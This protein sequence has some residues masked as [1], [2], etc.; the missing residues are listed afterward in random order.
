M[1]SFNG[2]G[3]HSKT[4]VNPSQGLL[5][6]PPNDERA[7]EAVLG[8][9]LIDPDLSLMV[10][11][12]ILNSSMFYI[13]KNGWIYECIMRLHER[14]DAVD[15]LTLVGE[16]ERVGRLD[17]IGGESYL[18]QLTNSVPTALNVETYA[19]SVANAYTRRRMIASA[20]AIAKEA[21]DQSKHLDDCMAE[22]G[23]AWLAIQQNQNTGTTVAARTAINSL[24]QHVEDMQ[25][26]PDKSAVIGLT[27]GYTDLDK[28]TGGLQKGDLFIVAGRPGMGKSA[29]MK[30]FA[31]TACKAG[32]RVML[33]SL[34]MD[35]A[36]VMT[37]IIS[38]ETGIPSERIKS[39]DLRDDEWNNFTCISMQ[40]A[41][42][43]LWID[44]GAALT[45]PALRAKVNRVYQQHGLD[46]IVVDYLQLMK[47]N[48]ENR[49]QEIGEITM[50]LKQIARE[51]K[52]PLV[53]GAQL[54]RA[55][56]QRNDKRPQLSDL[57]E[58]GSIENDA[59]IV[60]FIYRDEIYNPNTDAKNVAEIHIGK[61]RNGPTGYVNLFFNKLLTAFKPLTRERVE[62]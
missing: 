33:F 58:S 5:V 25:A 60:S 11:A 8:S 1:S 24:A 47:G 3:K 38:S 18:A 15:A 16:L 28:I 13:I 37:R 27:T 57:R 46:L 41:D 29:L 42:W 7:E 55:L 45:I 56:E 54:S 23:R 48:A 52:V 32:K 61:N 51:F 49:V 44:E 59:D 40:V 12:P 30:D 36:Q 53:A 62:L 19:Q 34:E 39:G 43:R 50:G 4:L 35:A 17:E 21:Y 14:H 31:V 6:L 26:R 2:N 22:S 10:V 9:L 20:S